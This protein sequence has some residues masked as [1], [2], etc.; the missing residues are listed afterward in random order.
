MPNW[1][2]SSNGALKI[3][4]VSPEDLVGFVNSVV[5]PCAAQFGIEVELKAVK[6]KPVAAGKH[7][8]T[9]I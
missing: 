9:R 7:Q 8:V 2:G 6:V 5:K 4:F 1:T 3:M